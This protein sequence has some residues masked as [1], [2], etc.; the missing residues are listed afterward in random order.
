MLLPFRIQRAIF[1]ALPLLLAAQSEPKTVKWTGWFSDANCA[2]SKLTGKLGPTNPD[3]SANCIKKGAAPVFLSEQA[4]ALFVV[5]GYP[6]LVDDLGYHMEIEGVIDEAAK[7]ITVK[8]A[9]RL[10]FDG[11]ACA[12]PR[13]R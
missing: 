7:T 10:G 13:K 1:L 9:T 12:R 11:A 6:A 2:P 3:C 8:K 5:K 4:K